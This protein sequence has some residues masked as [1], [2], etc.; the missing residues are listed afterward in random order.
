MMERSS[1]IA[2]LITKGIS[3]VKLK[4]VAHRFFYVLSF[5]RAKP[6]SSDMSIYILF[7]K[8]VIDKVLAVQSDAQ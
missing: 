7:V 2:P 1:L 3:D 4:I 8:M 5:H 6:C